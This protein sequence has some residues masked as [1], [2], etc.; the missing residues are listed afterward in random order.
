[1]PADAPQPVNLIC[2]PLFHIGAF[3]TQLTQTIT[4]G[5]IVFNSGRFD[6]G[7]VLEIIGAE[8]VQRWGAVPTMAVRLLE[9]PDFESYDLSTLRSFPMGGAPVPAV[10]LEKLARRL[11]QLARRGLANMWGMTEG[12]GFLTLAAGADLERFGDTVGRP[13]P[14]VELAIDQPDDNGVGEVLVRSPTV[15]TRYL[16]IDS[17][18][19]DSDGWLHTGDLGRLDSEGYLFIVGRSKDMVIRGGENVAC[20]HVEAALLRHPDVVEAAVIGLPHPELGEEI[21]AVVVYRVEAPPPSEEDL[22]R[23]LQELIAYFAIPTKW[24][25][26]AAPLPTIAGEKIDKKGLA[27]LFT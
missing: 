21:A 16:G 7:Q 9:H 3:A 5:R 8:G 2:T 14:T 4:G 6:A 13:L 24:R 15:M 11:P 20:P 17:G 1:L 18:T 26:T 27:V 12:G 19:I 10:L 22:A 25:I 23:H